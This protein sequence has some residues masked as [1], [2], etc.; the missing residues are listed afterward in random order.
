MQIYVSADPKADPFSPD[1]SSDGLRRKMMRHIGSQFAYQQ[2]NFV[3]S[4]C[5]FGSYVRF[6]RWD[7]AGCVVSQ[8]FNLRLS[9]DRQKL[10][11]FLWRYAALYPAFRGFDVTAIDASPRDARILKKAIR[12]FAEN[13]TRD[14]SH[15]ERCL[16]R[17]EEYPVY[18]VEVDAL[19]G[20]KLKLII[21]K[22]FQT[23]YKVGGRA[24][25]VYAAYLISERRLVALKDFWS[26]QSDEYMT[27]GAMYRL[28]QEHDVPNLPILLAAGDVVVDGVSQVTRTQGFSH[29]TGFTKQRLVQ[30]IYFPLKTIRSSRE[31]T[32]VTR[33]ALECTSLLLVFT[34][35][36][37]PLL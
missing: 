1:S 13:C 9:R 27:E 24:T 11:K 32:Q 16:S 5:I 36:S 26:I 28:L 12:H 34:T 8:R 31:L 23:Y 37:H 33:D 15:I 2:R 30:E 7:R 6:L 22:P 17:Y 20:T 29:F 14:T 19:D 4:I 18:R 35:L 25:R 10:A 3:F 21:G